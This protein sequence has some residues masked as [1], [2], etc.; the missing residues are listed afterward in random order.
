MIQ[1]LGKYEHDR[2]DMIAVLT[3]DSGLSDN[4]E[5]YRVISDAMQ[6]SPIPIVPV[7]SSLTSC[8]SKI[9]E[10]IG[11]GNVYFPDEVELGRALGQVAAWVA[12]EDTPPAPDGYD[13]DAVGQALGDHSG[14]LTPESVARV[15]TA[16]GFRLP[17]QI[18]VFDAERLTAACRQVGFPLA[19]KVIGPLHK[20]DVGGVRLGIVD[21]RQALAAW[22]DL[23]RIPDARGVLIQ[24][25]VKGLEVILGASREGEFGHLVMFGLGGIYTEVLKDVS[26]ALAP[27][28]RNESLR[29]IR[30]I[31]S[32]AVLEGVRGGAG[33]DIEVLA[34]YLQRLGCLVGDFPG[35]KEIDLNPVKGVGRDLYA[36]D[37]RII[38]QA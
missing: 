12:P 1:V 35:I 14:A 21:G 31:R 23:L 11:R 32:Y 30:G 33:M 16:A 17:G 28:S 5:I 7:L 24:P 27:L 2:I 26:F 34:D 36:V 9:A 25:M 20:T 10:F 3:G 6:T 13:R 38:M 29:M 37:A 4:A 18:E 19:M 15:L 8:E 22:E